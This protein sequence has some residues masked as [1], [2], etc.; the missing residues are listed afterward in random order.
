[1]WTTILTDPKV[2]ALAVNA[3]GV[4]IMVCT[5]YGLAEPIVTVIEGV[6]LGAVNL[7]LPSP[8]IPKE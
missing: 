7:F 2:R 5:H 6:L 8:L 3:V 4:A 1:M